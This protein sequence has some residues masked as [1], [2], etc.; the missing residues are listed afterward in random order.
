MASSGPG[1][2]LLFRFIR[3]ILTISS[4]NSNAGLALQE[5]GGK[6]KSPGPGLE[7]LPPGHS[8]T[9]PCR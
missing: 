9:M 5:S 4:R 3:I 2:N 1:Q 7:M 8:F 6:Q